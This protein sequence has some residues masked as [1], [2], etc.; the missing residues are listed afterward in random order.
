MAFN[1]NADDVFEIA[2]Q[3]EKNG[4]DFY[5]KA[6]ENIS[7]GRYKKLLLDLSRMEIEHKKIFSSMRFLL[8]EKEKEPAV[9]DP[10]NESVQYL[11]ALADMSVFYKKQVDTS[12]IETIFLDAI[13]MEKDSIVFYVGVKDLVPE[14]L[15]KNKI[16]NI[17]S[18]EKKH[19][20]LLVD[21]LLSL[22]K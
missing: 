13:S 12:K 6:S 3:I 7:D 19:I 10:M 15:G 20:K 17:I 18:E 4:A 2:E 11:K 1:F 16:E 5:N 9:F 22:K 21:E 8:S 14:R